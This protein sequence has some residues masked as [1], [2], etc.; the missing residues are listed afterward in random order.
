VPVVRANKFGP[1]V[2]YD[3]TRKKSRRIGYEETGI[4]YATILVP[5]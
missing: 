5:R 4:L 2:V 3:A 1:S